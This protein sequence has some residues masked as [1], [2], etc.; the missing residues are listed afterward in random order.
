MI[1]VVMPV[2]ETALLTVGTIETAEMTNKQQTYE[3]KNQLYQPTNFA[4]VMTADIFY[5]MKP[6][7]FH[8]KFKVKTNLN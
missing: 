3:P 6:F 2:P 5:F 4:L 7:Q 8:D 1:G